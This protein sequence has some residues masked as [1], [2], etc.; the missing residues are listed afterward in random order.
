MLVELG[1]PLTGAGEEVVGGKAEA[2]QGLGM[3]G[4]IFGGE[5][6][7]VVG[8]GHLDLLVGA[9]FDEAF[10]GQAIDAIGFQP[11]AAPD[12]IGVIVYGDGQIRA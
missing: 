10:G 5:V 6:A 11:Q 12:G 4:G 2:R 1:R 9:D 3:R 8:L 7:G